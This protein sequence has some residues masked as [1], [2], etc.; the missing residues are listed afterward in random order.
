MS[1]LNQL[2]EDRLVE[3]IA[4]L[5]AQPSQRRVLLG[6][7]DDAAVWQPSRSHR[8]VITTDATIEDVHFRR[9]KTAPEDIGRRA[10]GAALSDIAAMGAWPVLATI[11]IGLRTEDLE[12]GLPL[13]RGIAEVAQ[14]Y[15]CAIAGGDVSR[16]PAIAI[17]VTIVGEVR[18]S[19]IKTRAG[20]QPRDVIAVTGVLGGARAAGYAKLP[21]PRMREGRWLGANAAV[22]A[23]MDLSDGLSVDLARMCARSDCAALIEQIPASRGVSDADALAGGEEYE[24]LIAVAR[25]AFPHLACRFAKRFGRELERVGFFREGEGVFLKTETG[26]APVAPAGWDHFSAG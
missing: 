5:V 24:L 7:G 25:R 18:P 16:A 13:Y 19:H 17:V 6:I 8:S 11:S 22:H 3:A 1:A 15:D 20:A 12:V 26:E 23:M 9:D 2:R 21:E 14:K 10:M 4:E